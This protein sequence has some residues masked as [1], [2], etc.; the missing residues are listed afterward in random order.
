MV[1]WTGQGATLRPGQP[2]PL[3]W[4]PH[5]QGCTLAFLCLHLAPWGKESIPAEGRAPTSP[6]HHLLDRSQVLFPPRLTRDWDEAPF[7]CSHRHFQITLSV[8]MADFSLRKMV[9]G[10][11]AASLSLPPPHLPLNL[12]LSYPPFFLP[13]FSLSFPFN[14]PLFLPG[15][16]F[17]DT[18]SPSL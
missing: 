5:L 6:H 17:S 3:P 14:L 13:F 16:F 12:F 4:A 7:R 9:S 11:L 8:F 18:P 15:W 1:D 2:G 10:W